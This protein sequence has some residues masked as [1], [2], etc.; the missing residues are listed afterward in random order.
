[1]SLNKSVL[2]LSAGL[3]TA[4]TGAMAAE[5][6]AP[7][8]PPQTSDIRAAELPPVPGWYFSGAY[9]NRQVYAATD[10][11]G[12]DVFP[13][14]SVTQEVYGVG[15]LYVMPQKVYDGTLG[16]YGVTTWQVIEG[17]P[18]GPLP[19]VDTGRQWVDAVIGAVWSK[20]NYRMP[21][22]PPMGPPPGYAYALGL[23]LTIPGGDGSL[24]SPVIQPNVAFTYRTDPI[25]L[26]G[27]EFSTRVS[28]NHVTE[29][30]SR[31]VPGFDYKDGDYIAIDFAVTE[32]Y[33]NFQ[34]GLA[35]TYMKQI[36][37]DIPG[38]GYPLPTAGRMEEL[39]VG[40]VVNMDL[41]PTS[42]IRMK[43]TKG[44]SSANLSEGN[45][46]GIQYITKF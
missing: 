19:A 23:Q 44:V 5:E 26:D 6:L 34:F 38:A 36:E 42:A 3:I 45:L 9:G 14:T 1:M 2:A 18:G 32:R 46:F 28:Y 16:F 33:R 20:A 15:A 25:L 21:D 35:G 30:E 29:R 24:G 10:D 17:N 13:D 4:A 27:T 12:N 11:D 40:A 37:D 8:Q 31:L 22:G 7:A 41:G 39:A 43:Y